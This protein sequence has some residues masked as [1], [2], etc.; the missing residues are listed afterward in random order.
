[1]VKGHTGIF[2]KR[3]QKHIIQ[4]AEYYG[5]KVLQP[6]ISETLEIFVYETILPKES[7]Q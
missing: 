1:M 4:R 5:D 6:V 2:S 3:M 7:S